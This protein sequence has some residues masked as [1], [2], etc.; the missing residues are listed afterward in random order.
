M[1][2]VVDPGM[3]VVALQSLGDAVV[4]GDVGRVEVLGGRYVERP[5]GAGE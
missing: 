2:V 4:I 5:A 3:V 1:I